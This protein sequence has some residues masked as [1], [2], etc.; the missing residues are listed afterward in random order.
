MATSGTTAF[1]L[2]LTD[3]VAEAF[4]R[5]GSESRSGYDLRTARRSLNLL[6]VDWANRGVN[7]WTINFNTLVLTPGV[8]TYVLPDPMV[9]LIEH[10]IRT[11]QG[12]NPSDLTIS[13]ISIST[14]ATIP[15]K[16]SPGR[17]IQILVSRGTISGT[18][19]SD[20]GVTVTVWPVPDTASTYTLA[21]WFLRRM[22]DAGPTGTNSQDIPYRF[23][24]PMAAG[25][26]Y[27]IAMKIPEGLPRIPMLKQAYEEVWQRAS[28]EDREKAPVRFI[29]RIGML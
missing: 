11:P 4:E 16:T 3:L 20:S 23:L 25:L 29:P 22:Q 9:D 15:N 2:P 6:L 13:R 27:M 12:A 10:V 21:Y 14:Y 5:A 7:L 28:D 26:A 24:E 1:D 17:P 19:P 8:P 18:T